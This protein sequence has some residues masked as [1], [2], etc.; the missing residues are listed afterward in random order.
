MS[1]QVLDVGQCALDHANITEM[2]Q[3][4]FDVDVKRAHSQQEAVELA[5]ETVFDLI[6]VNRLLDRGGSS[7]IDLIK[8]LNSNAV[9]RR[10]PVMLVSNHEDAQRKAIKAGALAGFGKSS[11]EASGTIELLQQVLDD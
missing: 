7:G 6:L 9:A 5:N 11:L 4:Y 10:Q 2:L 8:K 3:Q 1:K